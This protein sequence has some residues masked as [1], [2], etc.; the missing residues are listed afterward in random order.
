LNGDLTEKV[1]IFLKKKFGVKPMSML[2]AF[3]VTNNP[4][5][6]NDRNL[7]EYYLNVKLNT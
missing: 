3:D 1:E 2:M 7:F 6:E 4:E 5:N